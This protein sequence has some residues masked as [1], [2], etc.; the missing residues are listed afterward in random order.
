M[1]ENTRDPTLSELVCAHI[2]FR[3]RRGSEDV[4]KIAVPSKRSPHAGEQSQI[5]R[6]TYDGCHKKDFLPHFYFWGEK[7]LGEIFISPP[8]Y[9]ST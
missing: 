4:L 7:F 2:K 3:F 8:Y 1:V 6:A 9:F 5:G